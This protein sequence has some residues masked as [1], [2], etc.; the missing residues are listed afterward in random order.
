MKR[1]SVILVLLLVFTGAAF[2]QKGKTEKNP[3][4]GYSFVIAKGTFS[5]SVLDKEGNVLHCFPVAIGENPG[6]KR[7]SGDCKTPE[8]VC[9]VTHIKNVKGVK[10]DYHDGLGPVEAYGPYFIYLDTPGFKYIGVHGTCPERD[11]RIGTR[12]SKGCIRLHN[13]DL[14]TVLPYAHP[15]MTVRIVPGLRDIWEDWLIDR[16][17]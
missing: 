13:E 10:Y 7:K 9:P 14:M 6:Q 17:N 12:D 1:W 5:L 15:G 16:K 2:A 8:G 11:D 3:Y 4:E